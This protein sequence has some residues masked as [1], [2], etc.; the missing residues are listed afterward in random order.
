MLI[1][2]SLIAMYKPHFTKPGFLI[3]A[4]LL[5]FIMCFPA[6]GLAAT[7]KVSPK[8]SSPVSEIAVHG[9]GFGRSE[10]VAIFFDSVG[11]ANITANTS[12][13]LPESKLLIPSDAIPGLHVIKAIGQKSGRSA[14]TDINV[15]TD[16]TQYG[17]DVMHSGFN[18]KENVL[19]PTNVSTLEYA[20]FS[21]NSRVPVITP[22]VIVDGIV[23]IGTTLGPTNESALQAVDRTGKLVWLARIKD[24]HIN[25]LAFSEG[26]LIAFSTDGFIRVYR[27]RNGRLVWEKKITSVI[28]NYFYEPTGNSSAITHGI[29][30]FSG[31]HGEVGA[32]K[33]SNGAKLWQVKINQDPSGISRAGSPIVIDDKVIFTTATSIYCPVLLCGHV[34]LNAVSSKSGIVIWSKP[35]S[36]NVSGITAANDLIFLAGGYAGVPIGS[37]PRYGYIAAI[38]A[39]SGTTAWDHYNYDKSYYQEPSVDGILVYAANGE[40][41]SAFNVL[42]GSLYW[43]TSV[44]TPDTSRHLMYKPTVSNGVVYVNESRSDFGSLWLIDA[45][46]GQV[47]NEVSGNHSDLPPIVVNGKVYSTSAYGWTTS[48]GLG[49]PEK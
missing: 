35:L 4:C 28:S 43:S 13:N 15:N 36:V 31:N 20:G 10:Q 14:Q 21:F 34:E 16:W 18:S 39:T 48:C 5:G 40:T 22:P 9:Q 32:Y 30:Y 49:N 38:N 46:N 44:S 23:Y 19:S 6:S 42:S 17:F 26:K 12:G 33:L 1:C 24:A 8:S 37:I 7:I 47:L 27:A 41:L 29:I 2:L 45:T 25:G 11:L 3:A